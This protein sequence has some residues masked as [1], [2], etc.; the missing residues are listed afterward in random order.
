[1]RNELSDRQQ[2]IRMRLAGDSVALICHTLRRSATWVNKWW[3]RYLT[4]GGEALYDLS[5]A[6]HAVVNRTP[7]YLE[8]AV[9]AIR[10]RLAARAT[11]RLAMPCW[12]RPPSQRN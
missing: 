12:V 6:R 8:R 4:A 2:A 9:L 10:R 5:R 11:P 3:Q 1:M 7:A